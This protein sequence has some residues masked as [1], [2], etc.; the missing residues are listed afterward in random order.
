M[1]A[2]EFNVSQLLRAQVGTT[3]HHRVDVD[4]PMELDGIR[5]W[6]MHGRVNLIRTNFGILAHADLEARAGLECDRCLEPFEAPVVARFDEEYLPIIDISTGRPVQ[7]ERTDE[8]FFISP[9]H[10]VDLT[11]AVRQN[12]LLAIPMHSV[13]SEDCRGLCSVCGTNRNLNSCDCVLEEEHPF[14]VIAGLLDGEE[15]A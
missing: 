7:S 1:E 15:S 2:L 8:T 12:L 11:E 14:A 9:N 4:T 10:V 13:C 3:T 5:T 6:G